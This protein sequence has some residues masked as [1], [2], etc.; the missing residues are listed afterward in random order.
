[1]VEIGDTLDQKLKWRPVKDYEQIK[2]LFAFFGFLFFLNV[3]LDGKKGV[4]C[5]S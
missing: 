3:I 1:L 2:H 4:M 5:H